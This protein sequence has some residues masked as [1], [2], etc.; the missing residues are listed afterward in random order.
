MRYQAV[1]LLAT[2]LTETGGV[3]PPVDLQNFV[4]FQ[5]GFEKLFKAVGEASGVSSWCRAV[6]YSQTN[7]NN[8]YRS[9]LSVCAKCLALV[10]GHFGLH[11]RW[12][13]VGIRGFAVADWGLLP[14]P[15]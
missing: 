5:D 7:S 3:P 11:Q 10:G 12:A 2:F 9:P 13:E 1:S 6:I 8:F 15:T 4:A 14:H